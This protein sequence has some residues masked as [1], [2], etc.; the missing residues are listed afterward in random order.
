M[1][2]H[3]PCTFSGYIFS[4]LLNFAQLVGC[5]WL[6]GNVVKMLDG[7]RK[8]KCDFVGLSVHLLYLPVWDAVGF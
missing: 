2:K 4:L 5:S 8:S 7:L 6:M 1:L 3:G